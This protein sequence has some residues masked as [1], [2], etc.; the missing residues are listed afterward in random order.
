MWVVPAQP[1]RDAAVE[2]LIDALRVF[3]VESDVFVDGFARAH[4]LG[5]SDL[6]AIMW[7]SAGTSSN[8]PIT[9]G[10]LA[11]R[12]GLSPAA[13]TALV[14]RLEAAGHISRDRDPGNRRRVHLRMNDRARQLASAF[15]V[16]LGRL[17]HDAAQEFS[18]DELARTTAVVRRFTEAVVAART[19]A[20]ER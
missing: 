3:T 14:D 7:I 11:Q 1:Q 20:P 6:N 8:H 4:G 18:E 5:R 10:E 9:I 17:M 13:A 19:A 12:I 15:F 16:P 2:D